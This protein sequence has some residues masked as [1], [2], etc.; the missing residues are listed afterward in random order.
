MHALDV[1]RVDENLEHGPR[2]RQLRNPLGIE[3]ER[4]VGFRSAV[5]RLIKIRP[6]CGLY[7]GGE[8]AQNPIVIE[9]HGSIEL[10]L[11]ACLA[12]FM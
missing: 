9:T 2:T 6:Q 8:T 7:R 4:N 3:L 1:G 10:G 5:L 11:H 12:A